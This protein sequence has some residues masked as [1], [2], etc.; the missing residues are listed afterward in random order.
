MSWI[1]TFLTTVRQ[2]FVAE[3]S[4]LRVRRN[5]RAEFIC[6]YCTMRIA[7]LS[8]RPRA[9]SPGLN[10]QAAGVAMR[11]EHINGACHGSRALS[12]LSAA[13]TSIGSS[14]CRRLLISSIGVNSSP[15]CEDA[16]SAICCIEVPGS[17][18]LGVAAAEMTSSCRARAV[19]PYCSR[20]GG[21][22]GVEG[23]GG[24]GG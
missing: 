15:G 13:S 7:S 12:H 2:R 18:R 3:P 17:P 14:S 1:K 9:T 4:A 21:R 6:V 20:W 19:G 24:K 16:Q 10:G 8:E 5:G 23:A 11:G 22:R